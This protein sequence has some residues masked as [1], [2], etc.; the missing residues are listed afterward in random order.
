MFCKEHPFV[1]LWR[2]C[3]VQLFDPWEITESAP[4]WWARWCRVPLNSVIRPFRPQWCDL[5]IGAWRSVGGLCVQRGE[6]LGST[7]WGNPMWCVQL[8]PGVHQLILDQTCK[9]GVSRGFTLLNGCLNITFSGD[10]I[11]TFLPPCYGGID[12]LPCLGLAISYHIDDGLILW[13]LRD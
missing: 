3:T 1:T 11:Y 13:A 12:V 2:Y 10:H 8:H 4:R 9:S 5:A 6:L 7:A